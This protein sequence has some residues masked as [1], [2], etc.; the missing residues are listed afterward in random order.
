MS[1]AAARVA[2]MGRWVQSAS[3]VLL[4]VMGVVM[5]AASSAGVRL[6]PVM[7][8]SMTPYAPA[9]ALVVTTRV[10][11][12]AVEVGD[13]VAFRPPAPYEVAG[14]RPVLHRVAALEQTST[15]LAMTTRGDANPGVD[16][17]LVSLRGADLARVVAVAPV[18]GA[19]LAGGRTAVALLLGGALALGV[20]ARAVVGYL[21]ERR[22]ARQAPL[23]PCAC[24]PG[25][26]VLET[27]EGLA[28]AEAA[29]GYA[30]VP[31]DQVDEAM[32]RRLGAVIDLSAPAPAELAEESAPSS[33]GV[34]PRQAKSATPSGLLPQPRSSAEALIQQSAEPG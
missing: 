18:G 20:V 26:E 32:S 15:G 28:A 17:W 2:R 9:G 34:P 27:T 7:T 8:G 1:P 14:H 5:V 24:T 21:L 10:D 29:Q 22:A 12:G 30:T 6:L 4:V 19:L 23:A 13:V 31:P 11:P 25:A 3:V 33:S 16:P